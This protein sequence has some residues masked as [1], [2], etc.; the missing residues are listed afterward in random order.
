MEKIKF[1]FN[2][3]SVALIGSTE[4]EKAVGRVILEN[5]LEA[6]DKCRIYPVNPKREKIFGMKCYPDIFPT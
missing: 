1:F 4:K 5:L 6:K 2:P 3:S